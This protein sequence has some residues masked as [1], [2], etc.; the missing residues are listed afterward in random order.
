MS[1]SFVTHGLWPTRLLCPWDSPGK[2][3]GVR[4][5]ALLQGIFHTQGSN[6]HLLC[7]CLGRQ[8]LD[9]CTTWEVH[10]HWK[11]RVLTTEPSRK[12]HVFHFLSSFQQHTL[13]TTTTTITHTYTHTA[14]A[15]AAF[16]TSR[17]PKVVIHVCWTNG[18]KC[19]TFLS[20]FNNFPS[21]FGIISGVPYTSTSVPIAAS[22]LTA[23]VQDP[24][25]LWVS[26]SS[27][28]KAGGGPA[29]ISFQRSVGIL[30]ITGEACEK[31]DSLVGSPSQKFWHWRWQQKSG[32]NT[33]PRRLWSSHRAALE[34]IHSLATQEFPRNLA[35]KGLADRVGSWRKHPCGDRPRWCTN[36]P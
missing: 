32:F 36:T 20:Q 29:R 21:S 2:N 7:P 22:R 26:A 11:C 34:E 9:H 6:P 8:I 16:N 15:A 4:C 31:V 30:R 24:G 35:W 33:H 13:P 17:S 23:L 27:C 10:Y 12:S 5:H 3:T 25:R 1:N 14:A 28:T 19:P 18:A